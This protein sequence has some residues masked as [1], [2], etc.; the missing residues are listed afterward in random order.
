MRGLTPRESRL[1]ALGLLVGAVTLV[2][3]LIV[4]PLIDGFADRATEHE[5][6][7]AEYR[8]GGRV[9]DGAAGWRAAAAAQTES[10]P[11]FALL[12]EDAPA[13]AQQLRDLLEAS[14]TGA[15][16]KIRSS[17]ERPAPRPD[18]VGAGLELEASQPQ[19]H[20]ALQNLAAEHPQVVVDMLSLAALRNDDVG[21][22]PRL[23]VRLEVSAPVSIRA[24]AAQGDGTQP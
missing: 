22:V 4:Q 12:A 19:V 15:G 23:A 7:T 24:P 6:L 16:A 21:A 14:F 8:R 20:E 3:G 5:E 10:A 2:Y 1:V 18:W 17:G 11:R 9:L 13:A